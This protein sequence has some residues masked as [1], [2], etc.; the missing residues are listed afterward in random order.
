MLISS[1]PFRPSKLKINLSGGKIYSSR[2]S[3]GCPII[4][5]DTSNIYSQKSQKCIRH[6]SLALI[7]KICLRLLLTICGNEVT[8]ITG[9]NESVAKVIFL[10]LFVI[11]FTG[12]CLPQC[13]LGY[14]HPLE[15]TPPGADTH[16]GS[17]HP[18]RA[19]TPQEQT[20]PS[21]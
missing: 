7:T 13:M 10:H 4:C 20:P 14:H 8:I 11:L 9:C 17:R 16:P 5:T 21:P 12:G 19:D 15:Q 2:T 18:P 3:G 1:S 6:K